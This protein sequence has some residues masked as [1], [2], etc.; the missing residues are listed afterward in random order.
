M[1]EHPE[2]LLHVAPRGDGFVFCLYDACKGDLD[3][4][5]AV[6]RGE[7]ECPIAYR[8]ETLK[9][10]QARVDWRQWSPTWLS[11]GKADRKRIKSK[12]QDV[13]AQAERDLSPGVVRPAVREWLDTQLGALLAVKARR[14][15]ESLAPPT[16]PLT[17][18][19]FLPQE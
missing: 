9:L 19:S 4:Y 18:L 6:M 5:H 1:N 11:L 3:L 16:G 7:F 14:L 10:H 13:L 15:V 12:A 8:C 17:Q 2:N